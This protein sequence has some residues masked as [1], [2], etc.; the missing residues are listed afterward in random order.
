M[1]TGVLSEDFVGL[2]SKIAGISQALYVNSLQPW[3]RTESWYIVPAALT[4]GFKE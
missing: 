1:N 2:S 3:L 4:V